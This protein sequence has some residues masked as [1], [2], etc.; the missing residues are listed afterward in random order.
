[1]YEALIGSN[2]DALNVLL[3]NLRMLCSGWV[4][5]SLLENDQ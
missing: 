4:V 1:M 3:G 2:R 5:I